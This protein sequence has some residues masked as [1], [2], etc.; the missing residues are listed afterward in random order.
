MRVRQFVLGL[1]A[2]D[3]SLLMAREEQKQSFTFN[4]DQYVVVAAI[5]LKIDQNL[6]AKRHKLVPDLIEE[7]DFWCNYFYKVEQFRSSIGLPATINMTPSLPT[8]NQ[9]QASR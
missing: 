2:D 8:F 5:M 9:S 1:A 6:S 7:E 4:M 3:N